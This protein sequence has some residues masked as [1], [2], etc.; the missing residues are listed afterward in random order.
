AHSRRAPAAVVRR[1]PHPRL[2]RAGDE[3]ARAR[4]PRAAPLRRAAMAIP[5]NPFGGTGRDVSRLGFGA[6]AIGGAWGA[7]DD[8][9]SLAALEHAMD[10]GVTF[11]DT[12]DVY[13]DGH[14][15]ALVG[16]ARRPGVFV[17]TKAG[18]RLPH[19]AVA[20]HSP[21]HPPA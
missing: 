5:T 18:R 7:T 12:A 13:G 21:P 20:G 6:W 8:G 1:P 14:S 9:A 2:V 4:G 11:I 3:G 10:L 17:A 16:R 15:E 19:Q